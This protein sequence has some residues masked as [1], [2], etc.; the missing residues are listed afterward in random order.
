MHRIRIAGVA[1]LLLVAPVA[2]DT[3]VSN[4]GPVQDE[5]LN[6]RNAAAAMV[7]GAESAPCANSSRIWRA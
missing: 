2:C 3:N 1:L 6:D 7:S 5:F 4:P